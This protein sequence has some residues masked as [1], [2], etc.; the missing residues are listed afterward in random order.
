[1][2]M[3][4]TFDEARMVI[5]VETLEKDDL[6]SEET[7]DRYETM[8]ARREFAANWIAN[9]TFA[10]MARTLAAWDRKVIEAIKIMNSM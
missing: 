6:L 7:I 1:M 4:M 5:E 10:E 3:T 8:A 2:T 9:P